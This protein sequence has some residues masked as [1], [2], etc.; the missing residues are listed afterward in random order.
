MEE[1]L[2]KE[3]RGLC[4][5]VRNS[6][7]GTSRGQRLSP[8]KHQHLGDWLWERDSEKER[9]KVVGLPHQPR[10]ESFQNTVATGGPWA[11]GQ[12]R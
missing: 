1:V 9:G 4:V 8:G 3:L 10:E 5:T 11:A 7:T 12:W 2:Q 6:M